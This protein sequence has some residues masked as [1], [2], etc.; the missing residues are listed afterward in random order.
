MDLKTYL[1]QSDVTQAELARHMGR[2]GRTVTQGAIS[3][4]ARGR[5]PA[6]RVIQL[7]K[8]SGGRVLPEDV[9]PDLYPKDRVA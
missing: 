6:E 1:Q 4:W 5:V 7:W 2:F 8:A 3:Q 9:R